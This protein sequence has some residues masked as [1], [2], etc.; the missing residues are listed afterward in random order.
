MLRRRAF[1]IG[2]G[3]GLV[4][5]P[6][7]VRAQ[8]PQRPKRIAYLSA[9][10]PDDFRSRA[11]REGLRTFGY[12]E[13]KDIVIEYFLSP[14]IDE[15]PA[16]AARAVA[17]APDLILAMTT[18]AAIVAVRQTSS[19]PIV[20]TGLGDPIGTGV[21]QSLARPGGNAT[22]PSLM[23]PDLAG[24]RLQLLSEF[25]PGLSRVAVLYNPDDPATAPQLDEIRIAAKTLGIEFRL[26]G[27]RSASDFAPI[28]AASA[29]EGMQAAIIIGGSLFGNNLE[30]LA[31]QVL[32]HRLPAIYPSREFADAGGLFT[33]GANLL[34]T[35][36]RAAYYVD[37]ILKGARPGDLPV[38][39]PTVFDFVINKKTADILGIKIPD[40]LFVF[41]SDIIE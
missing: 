3:A 29:A 38:E 4:A 9:N 6:R 12:T 13:G 36:R 18:P 31:A 11:F 35:Y 23:T 7:I 8:Q 27:V 41:A 32:R 34:E 2:A 25:R 28:V 17:A 26:Y 22:G 16:W 40:A 5:A 1:L 39:Q 37:R 14:S 19:I 15:L 24:K 10:P 30:L 33:Y 21:V 20:F